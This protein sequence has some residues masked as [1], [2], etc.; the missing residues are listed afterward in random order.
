[1]AL[2]GSLDRGRD[3]T[4]VQAPGSPHALH[5]LAWMFCPVPESL[6]SRGHQVL[7]G[8]PTRAEGRTESTFLLWV[9]PHPVHPAKALCHSGTF[10]PEH[11]GGL[12]YFTSFVVLSRLPHKIH[13]ALL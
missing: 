5:L 1:M 2:T 9:G 8:I 4:L 7:K 3:L 10:S 11:Q 13:I 12:S 6:G